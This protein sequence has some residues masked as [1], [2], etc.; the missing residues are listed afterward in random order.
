MGVDWGDYDNDGKL[1]LVVA[2]FQHE[3]KCIYHND[4]GFFSENS[5]MLGVAEKSAP[6]VAFGV[7][8]FDFDNDGW[9]DL[10]FA[11]GH[12]QDNIELIDTSETYLEKPQLFHNLN[13]TS[14]EEVSDKG[15]PAFQQPIMGRGLAVGDIDNDGRLDLLIIN[16][17]GRPLLLHNDAKND[18]HWLIC[19]LEGTKSNRDGIGARVTAEVGGKKLLRQCTTDGSY[20]SASDRRVHFGLGTEKSAT[21][22]V[23]WPDGSSSVYKDVAGDRVVTLKEGET[24]PR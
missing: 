1:D 7:K 5:A 11:N 14:F 13:G 17:E 18:N 4:G 10:A 21:I 12:V 6:Y 9:L 23:K 2:T 19:R 24:T 15:G 20:M 8:F 3:P 16:G 22:T